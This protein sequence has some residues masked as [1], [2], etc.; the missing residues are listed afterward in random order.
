MTG[1]WIALAVF[2]AFVL[3]TGLRSDRRQ[4][5]MRGMGGGASGAKRIDHQTKADEWGGPGY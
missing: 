2:I 4:R 3:V 5:G 1:F